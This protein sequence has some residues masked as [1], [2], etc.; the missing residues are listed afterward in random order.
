MSA[1]RPLHVVEEPWL[2]DDHGRLSIRRWRYVAEGADAYFQLHCHDC[3]MDR[4]VVLTLEP[5]QLLEVV[6]HLVS[7]LMQRDAHAAKDS[8]REFCMVGALPQE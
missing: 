7:T 5:S 6:G 4:D 1:A 3:D 2:A 8:G